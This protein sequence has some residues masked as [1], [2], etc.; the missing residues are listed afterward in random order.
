VVK[1]FENVSEDHNCK[2]VELTKYMMMGYVEDHNGEIY[3]MWNLLT[4]CFHLE[5]R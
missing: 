2:E 1:T 4:N 5:C 3:R